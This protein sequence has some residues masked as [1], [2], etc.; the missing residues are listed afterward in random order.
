MIEMTEIGKMI[1]DEGIMQ[2][3]IKSEIKGKA[4]GKAELLIIQL[5]KKFKKVPEEYIKKIKNLSE[6]TIEVIATE[7]FDLE[8]IEDIKR[9]L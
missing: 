7:I 8:R 3:E 5:T 6:T 9:Y 4:K 2:G 1:L